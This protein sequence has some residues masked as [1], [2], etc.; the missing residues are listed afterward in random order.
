MYQRIPKGVQEVREEVMPQPQLR[1]SNR[2]R[3]PNRRHANAAI[4]KEE[5]IKEPTT[6]EEASQCVEWRN[7]MKEEIQALRENQT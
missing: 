7:V 4:I 2:Q 3:K 5:N 6:Y 1:W